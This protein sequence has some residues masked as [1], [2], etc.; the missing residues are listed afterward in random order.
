MTLF[1]TK[2]AIFGILFEEMR[3]SLFIHPIRKIGKFE[4]AIQSKTTLVSWW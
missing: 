3:L 1:L 4:T 2:F